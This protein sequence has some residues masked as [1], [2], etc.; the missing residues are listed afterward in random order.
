VGAARLR[1]KPAQLAFANLP[2][3]NYTT[4][5][6]RAQGLEVTLSAFRTDEPLHIGLDST[7]MKVYGEGEWKVRKHG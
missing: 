5:C 7:G 2:V 1:A 6:R 3:P 4:L